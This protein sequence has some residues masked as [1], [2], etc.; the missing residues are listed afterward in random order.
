MLTTQRHRFGTSLNGHLLVVLLVGLVI[1]LLL[2]QWIDPLVIRGEAELSGDQARVML[3]TGDAD[4]DSYRDGM[5]QVGKTSPLRVQVVRTTA[6][7]I[8]G[9]SYREQLPSD[10]AMLFVYQ[11]PEQLNFVMREMRFPIDI[12]WIRA[13]VVVGISPNL[14]PAPAG[15]AERELTLYPAPEPVDWVLEVNAGW[16]AR[17]GIEIGDLVRWD[18]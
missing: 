16:S 12:V 3:Q 13:G 2:Q 4:K 10:A 9:L 17:H 15:I 7:Q 5:I 6:E 11:S 1:W 8:R 18:K 14:P